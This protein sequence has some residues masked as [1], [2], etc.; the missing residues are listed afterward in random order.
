MIHDN[1]VND[2][3]F[4]RR[5][6]CS[7]FPTDFRENSSKALYLQSYLLAD[8]G[9]NIRIRT[10]AND[11]DVNF[12]STHD[13]RTILEQNYSKFDFAFITC[14]AP[15]LGGSRYEAERE[16]DS[17]V[18]VEYI[19]RS[20]VTPIIKNRY[21]IWIGDDGWVIDDFGGDNLGL[22]IAECERNEPVTDLSIP[23]FIT[24]E[25]TD[26]YRFSNDNL[27]IKPFSEFKA[28]FEGELAAIGPKF[29]TMFGDNSFLE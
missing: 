22:I 4:E 6:F 17:Q 25:V 18:A 1:L 24:T 3:E 14:K 2:F 12:N 16:I 9:Y 19:L 7:S 21:S 13:W 29:S 10:T 20:K 8:E 28:D 26:D 15:T 11:I 23:K 27:S 5:F